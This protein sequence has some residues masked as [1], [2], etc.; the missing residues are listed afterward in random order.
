MSPETARAFRLLGVPGDADARTIRR[1]WRDLIRRFHPDT[2]RGGRA[3]ANRRLA[4]IN[5]AFDLVLAHADHGAETGQA[6]AGPAIMPQGAGHHP[7]AARQLD[8]RKPGAAAAHMVH[9]HRDT[10]PQT[11]TEAK[12]REALKAVSRPRRPAVL[13][14]A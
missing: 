12:L 10:N 2:L 3:E 9:K 6:A 13:R 14:F 11:E 4:D 5:A 7:V 1:A 8:P